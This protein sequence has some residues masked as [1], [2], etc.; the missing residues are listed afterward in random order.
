MFHQNPDMIGGDKG[1]KTKEFVDG[2][3]FVALSCF[4]FKFFSSFTE[5][6]IDMARRSFSAGLYS[7]CYI[8]PKK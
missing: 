7:N 5:Y 6:P 1:T 2:A 4:S 8:I 3:V